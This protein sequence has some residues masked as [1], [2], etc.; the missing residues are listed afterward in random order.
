[1]RATLLSYLFKIFPSTEH[2]KFYYD[3]SGRTALVDFTGGPSMFSSTLVELHINP[4]HFKDLLYILDGRFDHLRKLIVT[5][6]NLWDMEP[7]SIGTVITTVMQNTR[8]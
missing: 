3:S 5:L 2:L 7:F 8:R 4:Y 1:M 6:L